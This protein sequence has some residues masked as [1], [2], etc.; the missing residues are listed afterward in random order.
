MV[1]H[2]LAAVGR[3]DAQARRAGAAQCILDVVQL[4]LAHCARVEGGDLVVV[5]VG[6]DHRL[7]GEGLRQDADV[8]GGDL[9][10]AQVVQVGFGIGADG[11]H[12]HGIAAKHLQRVGD[13]AGAA[14]E[15]AAH[16]GHQERDVQ[17]VDLVRQD[18][19]TEAS[20]ER[21]DGVVGDGAAD[22]AGHALSRCWGD[23]VEWSPCGQYRSG[24]KQKSGRPGM[25][26][27]AAVREPA[28]SRACR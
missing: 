2:A 3:D 10:L 18:V 13:V 21:H 28:G 12:H 22:Q 26:A 14:A 8:A 4:R 19:F 5:Q 15:L 25:R 27:A 16:A 1:Q 24:R 11:G 9:Q 6:G 7:R 17:H 23:W 20:V